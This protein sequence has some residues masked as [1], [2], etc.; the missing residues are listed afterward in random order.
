MIE[1]WREL[2]RMSFETET[3]GFLP[4]APVLLKFG[5]AEARIA[6]L[7]LARERAVEDDELGGRRINVS[8]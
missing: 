6:E 5:A 1:L 4:R 7:R 3:L 8:G 2:E